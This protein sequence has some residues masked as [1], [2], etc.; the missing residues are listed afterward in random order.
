MPVKRWN[1]HKPKWSY[2]IA[3]MNNFTKTLLPPDSLDV[4]VAYQGFYNIIKKA[5][6]KTIHVVIKTTIFCV[7][8]QNVNLF[9]E[10]FRNLLREMT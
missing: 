8:M 7:G 9:V 2:Y 5:A 1:F 3:L 6:K 4:N 10:L